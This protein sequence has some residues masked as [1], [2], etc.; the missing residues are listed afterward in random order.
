MTVSEFMRWQ[1]FD[2]MFPIGFTD[3]HFG[4]LMHLLASIYSKK[5]HEPKLRDFTI[6]KLPESE[7]TP[8]ELEAKIDKLAAM[9][10]STGSP[11]G[12]SDES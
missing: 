4:R 11:T 6:G 2:E 3:L 7:I 9:Y 5:G 8:E 12:G 1:V 10:G